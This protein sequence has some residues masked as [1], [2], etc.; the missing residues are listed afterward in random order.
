MTTLEMARESR[1]FV[2]SIDR[3]WL[4][5]IAVFAALALFDPAQASQSV[6]DVLRS[7]AHIAPY[8]LLAITAAAYTTAS[9][10]DQLIA[11]AFQGR[12]SA[13]VVLAAVFGAVSPFCSCG[14]IPLIAALLAMGVPIAPVMAFWL[15]SPLM[16]PS[17]FLVTA[18]EIGVDF[19][20]A[21]TLLAVG[22]GLWGGFGVMLLSNGTRLLDNPLKPG[23]G[24]GGCG[25]SSVRTPS[26]VVW[27]F[28]DDAARREKFMREALRSFLFLAKWLTLAYLMES[29]FI[30]WIPAEK[31]AAYAGGGS[32][33]SIVA[34]AMLSLP[35]YLNGFA[36]IPLI[37]TLMDAGMAPGAA[38]AFVMGGGVSCI[39]AA[40]GVF[41]LVRLPVFLSYAALGLTGAMASGL[42]YQLWVTL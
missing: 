13:M 42:A 12:T 38:M 11:R 34:A 32:V 26:A 40:I 17:M 14:V 10:A 1:R 18:G 30:A 20:V 24:D 15:A 2:L 31:V 41:A 8:L 9:S 16:D 29:L 3:V 37:S 39:P 36:A 21:K 28:W 25:A 6:G 5:F 33:I 35:L 22:L 19:A 4:V 7:M 27:R 23:V